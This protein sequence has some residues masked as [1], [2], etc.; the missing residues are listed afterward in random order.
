V[1][2]RTDDG[3]NDS[4]GFRRLQKMEYHMTAEDAGEGQDSA[5]DSGNADGQQASEKTFTQAQLTAILDRKIR[6]TE[7]KYSGFDEIKG[8]AEQFDALTETAKTDIQRFQDQ[9]QST[10]AERDTFKADNATLKTQLDRQKISATKGL[11]PD[12]WDRVTGSTAEEITADV[13]KLVAKF[14]PAS[15]VTLG[16][17]SG[18]GASAP[19][20]KDPKER[21]ANAVRGLRAGI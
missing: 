21:A 6:E 11:D 14:Q 15:R 3:G 18:S 4:G 12:L 10:S 5:A 20:G 17:R 8:K 9:L 1:S 2:C 7:S 19:D 16:S 13:E